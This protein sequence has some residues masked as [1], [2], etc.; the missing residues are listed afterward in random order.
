MDFEKMQSKRNFWFGTSMMLLGVAIG[1]FIAPVKK[2]INI[3]NICGNGW[4][5]EDCMDYNE[6]DLDDE[7]Y[8]EKETNNDV[9]PF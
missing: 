5:A 8:D 6:D 3:K 4:A 2:G 9:I 7:D 1:Y